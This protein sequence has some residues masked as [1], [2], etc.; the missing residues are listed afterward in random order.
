MS[1]YIGK[2]GP[3]G[4]NTQFSS[5]AIPVAEDVPIAPWAIALGIF[6]IALATFLRIRKM[7]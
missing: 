1:T 3:A 4:A 5:C 6:L 7:A 2:I